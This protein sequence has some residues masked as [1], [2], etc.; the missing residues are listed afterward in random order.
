MHDCGST[1][2]RIDNVDFA[3]AA[4]YG[5]GIGKVVVPAGNIALVRIAFV[6]IYRY[7]HCQRRAIVHIIVVH[8]EQM[9]VFQF[10]KIDG[11]VWIFKSGFNRIRS[12]LK[13]FHGI[14]QIAVLWVFLQHLDQLFHGRHI[15]CHGQT[16]TQ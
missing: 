11:R 13:I 9:A 16:P 14:Q 12:K 6:S 1:I 3:V 8:R 10:D 5:I 15:I 2:G 7:R 4:W